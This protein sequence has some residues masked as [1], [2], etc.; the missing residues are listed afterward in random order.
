[1][2]LIIDSAQAVQTTRQ[3]TTSATNVDIPSVSIADS[4]FN[5]GDRYLIVATAQVDT[6]SASDEAGIVTVHGTTEFATSDQFLEHASGSNPKKLDYFWFTVWTAV[7][8]EGIKMQFRQ[9]GGT[10]GADQVVLTAI[11]LNDFEE[12]TDWHFD[13]NTTP[14]T[15][16]T[17]FSTS[18]N[19]SATFT[20]PNA[21]DDWLVLSTGRLTIDDGLSN[22][23]ISRYSRSGEASFSGAD[24]SQEREIATE[25]QIQTNMGVFN[26]GSAS[27]TFTQESR[28]DETNGSDT[29]E[30]SAI[31]ILNLRRFK[32]KS[33]SFD[34]VGI[35]DL[36]NTPPPGNVLDN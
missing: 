13:E 32:N 35:I 36:I 9:S 21:G 31:L 10:T 7:A 14:T 30:S 17:S 20:P 26:L 22:Q 11:K 25:S 18:N 33:S 29:R 27:N 23:I 5:T 4:F 16:T 8:S 28:I 34:S 1:M 15:L 24:I 12:G 6:S 19:A 2:G 3:T